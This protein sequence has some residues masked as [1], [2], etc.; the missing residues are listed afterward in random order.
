MTDNT[1]NDPLR[2]A[3]FDHVALRAGLEASQLRAG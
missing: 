2:S 3:L 1:S